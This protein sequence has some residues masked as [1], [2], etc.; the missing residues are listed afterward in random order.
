MTPERLKELLDYDHLSGIITNKRTKRRL[1]ADHDGL[2]ILFDLPWSVLWRWSL[3]EL[4]MLWPSDHYLWVDQRVLHKNLDIYDNRLNNLSLVSRALFLQIKE[5]HKNILGGIKI[6]A[7]PTDQ[8]YYILHWFENGAE[9]TKILQDIV[10][11]RELQLKLQLKYSK[12]LQ[13]IVFLTKF[14]LNFSGTCVILT[15]CCCKRRKW[16]GCKGGFQTP[17]HRLHSRTIGQTATTR[18][19]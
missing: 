9:K 16:N 13:N 12:I 11:A 1:Q 4:P 6:V 10:P 17:H 19:G 18:I 3:T 7:H 15:Y 5:A 8:F 2:V 14:N